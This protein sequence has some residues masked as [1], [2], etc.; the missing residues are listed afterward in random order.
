MDELLTRPDSQDELGWT[1]SAYTTNV[2][3]SCR[4]QHAWPLMLKYDK[5]NPGFVGATTQRL[6]GEPDSE[7][8]IVLI[9]LRAANGTLMPGFYART[10]KVVL[11]RQI[12]WY[13]Y[14]TEGNLFQ[15]FVDFELE[16]LAPEGTK[17][18][19]HW[20][21]LDRIP[22]DSVAEHRRSTEKGVQDLAIAFRNYCI[23]HPEATG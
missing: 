9:K 2:T 21:A 16:D 12:A 18:R 4:L 5:W 14:S 17:F 1:P 20:Y 3:L 11:H 19:I 7:G 13:S 23:A 10:L 15:N 6:F 8:E 22:A